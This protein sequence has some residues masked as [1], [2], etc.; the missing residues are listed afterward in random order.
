MKMD[1]VIKKANLASQT[2]S[3]TLCALERVAFFSPDRQFNRRNL[4]GCASSTNENGCSEGARLS[5]VL[6]ISVDAMCF[7]E[8]WVLQSR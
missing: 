3:W 6:H 4:C 8:G 2:Y 1:A 5:C 7:V